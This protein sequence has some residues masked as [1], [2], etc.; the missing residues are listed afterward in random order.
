LRFRTNAP[1][2][3]GRQTEIVKFIAGLRWPARCR[4]P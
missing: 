2:R 3:S 1:Q 4:R